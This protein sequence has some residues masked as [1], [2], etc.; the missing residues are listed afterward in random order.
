MRFCAV[1]CCQR[2]MA[3]CSMSVWPDGTTIVPASMNGWSVSIAPCQKKCALL[4]S[5][6]PAK[7]STLNGPVASPSAPSAV[8]RPRPTSSDVACWTPTW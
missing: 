2:R 3:A 1:S 6:E 7:S 5:S 8:S 4:S